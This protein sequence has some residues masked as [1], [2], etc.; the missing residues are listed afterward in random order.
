[1]SARARLS[2]PKTVTRSDS[3]PRK[4]DRKSANA[5]PDGWELT[6]QQQAFIDLFS[7]DDSKKQ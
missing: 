6:K 4:V 2:A 1:M 5:A 7:E 3:K